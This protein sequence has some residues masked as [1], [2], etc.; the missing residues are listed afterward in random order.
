M[1]TMRFTRGSTSDTGREPPVSSSTVRPA[2]QRRRI[3]SRDARWRRGSPPVSSTNGA[4]DPSASATTSSTGRRV[5]PVKVNAESHQVQRRLQRAVRMNQQG[6]P[7][8]VD[9]PWIDR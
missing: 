5:P 2:S 4:P 6:S 8:K 1:S 7:A 9:S 3:T